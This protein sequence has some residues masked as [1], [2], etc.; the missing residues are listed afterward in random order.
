MP[1]EKSVGP[2]VQKRQC[3][4]YFQ[5]S[6]N[7]PLVVIFKNPPR[8]LASTIVVPQGSVLGPLIYFYYICR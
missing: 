1:N 2:N 3:F 4:Y 6:C 8:K 7:S 5:V